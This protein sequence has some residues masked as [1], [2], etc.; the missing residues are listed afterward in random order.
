MAGTPVLMIETP[1]VPETDDGPDKRQ[2]GVL[3][4]VLAPRS[5]HPAFRQWR[6]GAGGAT[7][8]DG[9]TTQE[10][11]TGM[12][13]VSTAARTSAPG[14]RDDDAEVDA[15]EIESAEIESAEIECAESQ[16][17][18][19]DAWARHAAAANGFGDDANDQSARQDGT[20]DQSGRADPAAASRRGGRGRRL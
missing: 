14:A 8:H 5:K 7:L 19:I 3:V 11:R 2:A 13:R 20:Q 15:A 9:G 12:Q 1:D 17:A 18:V 4:E 6:S 16:A 10:A